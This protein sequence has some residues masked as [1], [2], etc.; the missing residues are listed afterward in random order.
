VVEVPAQRCA[1]IVRLTEEQASQV[2]AAQRDI[3]QGKPNE[4]GKRLGPQAQRRPMAIQLDFD[5]SE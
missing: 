3:R 4:Q 1:G 2:A 5:R